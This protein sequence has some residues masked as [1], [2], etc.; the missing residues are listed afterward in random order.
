MVSQWLG[1]AGVLVGCTAAGPDQTGAGATIP[2][3]G[4]DGGLPQPTLLDALGRPELAEGAT[5]RP[6]G[7][8]GPDRVRFAFRYNALAPFGFDPEGITLVPYHAAWADRWTLLYAWDGTRSFH[9]RATDPAERV[10]LYDPERPEVATLWEPLLEEIARV[11]GY[12]TTW[13][14]V[15]PGP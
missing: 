4:A 12:I 7:T 9:D 15:D 8:A 13:T 6:L 2:A 5:G 14:P 1:T 11:Q 10:D 3:V